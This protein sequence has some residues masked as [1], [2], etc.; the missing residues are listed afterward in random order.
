MLITKEFI[1]LYPDEICNKTQLCW[2][3]EEGLSEIKGP[4]LRSYCPFSSVFK[5]GRWPFASD[6]HCTLHSCSGRQSTDYHS[7]YKQEDGH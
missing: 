6:N 3:R 1:L 4:S 2:M 7:L 5:S